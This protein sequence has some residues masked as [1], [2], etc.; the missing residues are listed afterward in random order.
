MSMM[1]KTFVLQRRDLSE[2]EL[3]EY[4]GF[5]QLL[6]GASSTQTLTL[7]GYKRGGIPLAIVTLLIWILPASVIMG[8]LSFLLDYI[9]DKSLKVEVFKYIR[10][11]AI[12]FIAFSTFRIFNISVHNT[13]TK[14]IMVLATIATFLAFKSP[15]VFPTLI[16]LAGVVTNFSD[17]R[18]PSFN[19]LYRN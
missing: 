12:G 16:V 5:C 3:I 10:P 15:W 2:E 6:P 19:I 9:D 1:L 11:M 17:R 4:N 18:I 8:A 7:I 14:I 13:I